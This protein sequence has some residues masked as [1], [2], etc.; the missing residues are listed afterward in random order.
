VPA[1][2]TLRASGLPVAAAENFPNAR[3]MIPQQQAAEG[4]RRAWPQSRR[5]RARLKPAEVVVGAATV[6]DG[7]K[8]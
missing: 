8:A 1:R 5:H 2:R 6:A 7:A 4:F 3:Q